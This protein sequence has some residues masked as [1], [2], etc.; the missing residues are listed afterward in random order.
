[1]DVVMP[2]IDGIDATR[3][4]KRVHPEMR[5][6]GISMLDGAGVSA[7]MIEAGAESH[8]SKQEASGRLIQAICRPQ[9]SRP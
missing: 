8:L 3:Q 9:A 7:M 1:M 4:I 6:I 5:V 2:G